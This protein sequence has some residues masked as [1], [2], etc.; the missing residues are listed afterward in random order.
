[1]ICVVAVY[2]WAVRKWPRGYQTLRF[3]VVRS[4]AGECT[5]LWFRPLHVHSRSSLWAWIPGG[6]SVHGLHGTASG[7]SRWAAPWWHHDVLWTFPAASNKAFFCTPWLLWFLLCGKA[8]A[9]WGKIR[10]KGVWFFFLAVCVHLK[11]KGAGT[12][13][14]QN[15]WWRRRTFR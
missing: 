11:W 5:V 9:K 13:K 15:F 3:L 4:P 12:P 2:C 14:L 8:L 7:R 10:P 1:M 6:L